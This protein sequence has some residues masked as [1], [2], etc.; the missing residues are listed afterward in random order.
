MAICETKPQYVS[1]NLIVNRESAPFDNPLVRK[2]MA[3]TIELLQPGALHRDCLEYL[4][5]HL[6]R[7]EGVAVA[8]VAAQVDQHTPALDGLLGQ[9][10]HAQRLGA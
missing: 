5:E 10:L 2:A 3:L 1:R 9:A 6:A 8:K 7:H 4:L